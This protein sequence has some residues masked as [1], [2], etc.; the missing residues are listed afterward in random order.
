MLALLCTEEEHNAFVH[1]L[2]FPQANLILWGE[3]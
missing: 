1:N 2:F 3:F